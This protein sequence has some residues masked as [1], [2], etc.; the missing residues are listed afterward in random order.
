MKNNTSLVQKPNHR[1]NSMERTVVTRCGYGIGTVDM[2][3]G[4][5]EWNEWNCG[6]MLGKK[7]GHGSVC[8]VAEEMMMMMRKKH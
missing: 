3:I 1:K 5:V 7:R 4:T 2:R 8:S 6:M